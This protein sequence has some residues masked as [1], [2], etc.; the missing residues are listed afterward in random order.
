[1]FSR[2]SPESNL[3]GILGSAPNQLTS[4]LGLGGGIGGAIGGISN[5]IGGGAGGVING[6]FRWSIYPKSYH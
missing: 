4:A 6:L 5:V 1:M 2:I 3:N